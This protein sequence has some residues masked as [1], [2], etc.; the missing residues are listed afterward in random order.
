MSVPTPSCSQAATPRAWFRELAQVRLAVGTSWL[1]L[2]RANWWL[3]C[4]DGTTGMPGLTGK[5]VTAHPGR[6]S[7][8]RRQPT[9][10]R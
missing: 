7:W 2:E 6:P 1:P 9:T 8:C 4:P 5:Q 3:T 10:T